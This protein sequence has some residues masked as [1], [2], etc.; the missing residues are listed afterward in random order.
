MQESTTVP[1][2]EPGCGRDPLV[3]AITLFLAHEGVRDL[4]Y[5]REL[6]V[7]EIDD[8]GPAALA[9][10][11][12][13]LTTTGTDWT[14]YPADP[15]A[16]RIHHLLGARMLAHEPVLLGRE[17]LEA[18]ARQPVVLVANHL[19]YA[20]ANALEFVFRRAGFG[21]DADRLTVVAGPKVYSDLRRR[22]SSLCFGTIRT[23]QSSRV[24]TDAAA[25]GARDVARAARRSIVTA[26]ERLRLGD[27]LVVF[28]EGTRSRSGAMQPLLS[29]VARYLEGPPALVLPVAI[30]GTETLFPVGEDSLNPVPILA[31]VGRAVDA[32][33]LLAATGGDRRL[34]MDCVGAAIAGLLPP[35]YRGAYDDS[36]RGLDQARRLSTQ[37]FG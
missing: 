17:H 20:D 30:I 22:F 3:S 19:S 28:P 32:R 13:R 6:L 33:A 18:A 25:T 4:P 26:H 35:E 10:L 36:A 34:T 21:A 1:A 9:A 5:L 24:S 7:R 31:R 2:S 27:A 23:P 8:A 37:L 29:A 16:R 15:L 14:Y 12:G 11:G